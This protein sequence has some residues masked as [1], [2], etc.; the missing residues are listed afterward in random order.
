MLWLDSCASLDNLTELT[1]IAL[2]Y[3]GG[4]LRVARLGCCGLV[5]LACVTSRY[6]SFIQENENIDSLQLVRPQA[7]FKDLAR[8]LL[9]VTR[10]LSIENGLL[11]PIDRSRR[12][13]R[14]RVPEAWYGKHEVC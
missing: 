8:N 3:A 9:V 6:G 11:D 13:R 14:L 5:L 10:G 1:G 7:S 2:C 12:P 4:P